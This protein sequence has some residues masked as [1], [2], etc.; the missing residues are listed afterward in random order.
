[1]ETMTKEQALQWLK[2][3]KQSKQ[4]TIK[5]MTDWLINDFEKRTGQKPKYIETL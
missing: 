3:V 4:N 5:R 1:M 2:E